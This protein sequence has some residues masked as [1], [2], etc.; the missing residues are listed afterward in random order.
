MCFI[1]ALKRNTVDVV[2]DA[3]RVWNGYGLGIEKT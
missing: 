2:D 3:I 1:V